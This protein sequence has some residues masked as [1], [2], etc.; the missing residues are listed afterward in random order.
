[1][2]AP[3]PGGRPDCIVIGAGHNGLVCA[4][5]LA[6]G[7]RRVLV[8]EAA[9]RVGGAAITREFAPGFR[10]SAGAHLLHLMPAALIAELGLAGHGLR[11]AASGLPTTALS[12]EGPPLAIDTGC[13]GARS[14]RD[15]AAYPQFAVRLARFAAVLQPLLAAAPPRL[16]T[17]SWSDALSLAKLAW[18]IRRLGRRDMRELLR[19]IGMNVYDLLEDEFETPLLKGALGLDAVLGTNFGPRAPGTVLTYLY[20]LAGES[21][22][23]GAPGSAPLAL[24][25]GGLGALSEALARAATAAGAT[26]RTSAAV[27]RIVVRADR[28]VGVELA[29]GEIIEAGTVVSNA[30]PKTTFLRLLGA[31]HLDTGFVRRVDHLRCLGV[32]AKLHLAL[33]RLP[34]FPGVPPDALGGRLLI[35]PSL[36]YIERAWN[37][38]KYGECSAEP[39][40]E[41]TLPSVRDPTL[42]PAGRHV[43]SAIVQYAPYRPAAGWDAERPR[44]TRSLIAALDRHA[45]GL[46]ATVTAAELLTPP[47]IEREFRI[48]GGHW[49]HGELAFDQFCMVRPVPGAAQY[50]TPLAG[51]Y[52]CGAGCHPG[53]GVMGLAGRNAARAVTAGTH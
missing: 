39:V 6:R 4:T 42:A 49:H 15:A 18:R 28:A 20:R 52:L 40:I 23:G 5:Y 32:A 34:A 13:L 25:A 41:V 51:L 44:F 50:A 12:T 38:V 53:G 3:E 14:P 30:D 29:S 48:S 35:A 1:M 36:T 9:E 16:G 21:A 2:S 19:I 7:G 37:H 31:E 43:L 10:V 27:A 8:L 26:I 45:P 22:A 17:E 24:P 47:D 11:L 46:Q 33:E